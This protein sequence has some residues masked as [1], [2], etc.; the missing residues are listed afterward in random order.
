MQEYHDQLIVTC[1]ESNGIDLLC[2][3]K[4]L[5]EIPLFHKISNSSFGPIKLCRVNHD[6]FN[7]IMVHIRRMK[8]DKNYD[9][10]DFVEVINRYSIETFFK[11][12][13]QL[14]YYSLFYDHFTITKEN[15]KIVSQQ[16]ELYKSIIP[17]KMFV[18]L[19]EMLYYTGSITQGLLTMGPVTRGLSTYIF[20]QFV[21]YE[22]QIIDK[23]NCDDIVGN[24]KNNLRN[25]IHEFFEENEEL[26][27][28][29]ERIVSQFYHHKEQYEKFKKFLEYID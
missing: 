22:N 1:A 16:L 6:L 25:F 23:S 3:W 21:I 8:Y 5:K 17:L 13:D 29:Q 18:F 15:Y 10:N 14:E 26:S 2:Q 28:I 9:K 19:S 7:D 12:I 27:I 4:I 24:R 11:S 20:I